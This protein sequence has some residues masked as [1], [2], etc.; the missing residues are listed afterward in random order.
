MNHTEQLTRYVAQFVD[1]L[2]TNGLV[3][4]V[5]SPGSRSTPLAMMFAHHP[6][7]KT[8]V[9]MDERSASFFALGMAKQTNC[10]VALVCTSGTAAANYY[11]AIIE[12]YYSRV[13]L[14]VLTADRPHELR[15]VGAPQSI[16]QLRL[17]GEYTK[18]FQELSLPDATKMSLSYIRSVAARA[19]HLSNAMNKGAI[20]LNF[21]F[22]EPLVPDFS[23]SDLWGADR[24]RAQLEVTQGYTQFSVNQLQQLYNQLQQYRKGIIVC[25][26]M[27]NQEAQADIIAFAKEW[28]LPVF[29]DP[30]SQLRQGEA[31]KDVVIESYDAILKDATNRKLIKPDFVIRFGAMPISK[32]Y[33]LW[34]KEHDGIVHYVVEEK[35][36]FREPVGHKTTM[37]YTAP[38]ILCRSFMSFSPP[39]FDTDWLSKWQQWNQHAVSILRKQDKHFLTEGDAVLG[40]ADLIPDDSTLFIG[41]SMAIRDIDT[42]WFS[43]NKSIRMLC[44]RGANGIDGVISSALGASSANKRVTL[45]IGDL[46]FFHD[47]NGLLMTKHYP[48]DITIV[49]INNNGGGIFSFLPQAKQQTPYYEALFGTPLDIDL[50]HTVQLY[51]GHYTNPT[52]WD[53]YKQALEASYKRPGLSVIELKTVR[54]ENAQWHENKWREIALLIE[55]EINV[56]NNKQ[57]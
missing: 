40:L 15:D 27:E 38:R 54:E 46:S 23:L 28:K 29:A 3:N 14:L 34:L 41:N 43:T 11:P 6:S 53:E 16:N 45:L 9:N 57:L 55:D 49:L 10:P 32:A 33:M 2:A 44:N 26:P 24:T 4:V 36:G 22:R 20:H 5:I 19:Y 30:L 48:L 42:F 31:D 8:W 35:E 47:Q 39:A 18:W 21:P 13:P 52:G 56:S 7:I 51:Q 37:L 1:E 25:G 12:A 50:A 17:F